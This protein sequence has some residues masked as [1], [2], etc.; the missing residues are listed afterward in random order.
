[1]KLLS[2]LNLYS[3]YENLVKGD[4]FIKSPDKTLRNL[5]ISKGKKTGQSYWISRFLN[6]SNM[7]LILYKSYVIHLPA[8]TDP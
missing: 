7:K 8:S 6:I 3:Q 2:I 4:I 1:M 5:I